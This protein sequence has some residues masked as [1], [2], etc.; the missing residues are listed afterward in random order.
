MARNYANQ[1]LAAMMGFRMGSQAVR[2]WREDKKKQAIDDAMGEIGNAQVEPNAGMGPESSGILET[3]AKNGYEVT[4]DPTTGAASI[5]NPSGAAPF[6][7][8]PGARFLGK[9]YDTAPTEADQDRYRLAAMAGVMAKNGN[10]MEAQ[11][12]KQQA[13]QTEQMA[14]QGVLT[15]LQ[16]NEAKR[17]DEKRKSIESIDKKSGEY[18]RSRVKMDDQGSPA[19]FTADDFINGAKYNAFALAEAG[20]FQEASD[21]ARKGFEQQ[22]LKLQADTAER[23]AVARDASGRVLQGDYSGAMNL[24]NKYIPDGSNATAAVKNN[25]GSITVDRVSTVDGKKLEPIK[26]RDEQHM[27]ASI[28]SLADPH[29]AALYLANSWK[30]DIETRKVKADE[31]RADAA[32]TSAGA[33]VTTANAHVTSVGITK[34]KEDRAS[35]RE[36]AISK[37][38]ADFAEA[39]AAGDEK[40]MNAARRAILASGGK[41]DKPEVIKP[42]VKVGQIGDITVSQPTGKGGVQVT[43]YGPDMKQ[44]GSVSV[45]APGAQ[46]APVAAPK[47]KADFD[48]LPAGTVY[49]DPEDGKKYRKP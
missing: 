36:D 30:Q 4:T 25:D 2:D 29:A 32:V 11:R 43:N 23:S 13:A 41:L 14:K 42:E 28:S 20:H 24:F 3:A 45:P 1:G 27:A 38:L 37:G 7:V 19:P 10:P 18:M 12:L 34:S 16:I 33:S 17:Q 35:T 9:T 48:K 6:V 21:Q 31:K 49:I 46:A 44:K 15:D 26:F 47:T 40:G 5:V 22:N 8:Q 39:E